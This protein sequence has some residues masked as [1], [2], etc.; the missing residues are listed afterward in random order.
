MGLKPPWSVSGSYLSARYPHEHCLLY[1]PW[2]SLV[3]C[4]IAAYT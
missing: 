4:G 1:S 2:L 3:T